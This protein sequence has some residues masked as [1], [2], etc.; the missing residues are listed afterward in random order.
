MCIAIIKPAGIAMPSDEILT[1]CWE[2]NDDGAGMAYPCESGIQIIKGF[3]SLEEFL[4]FTKSQDFSIC[5]VLLHFRIGTHGDK[6]GA[7]HTHPFPIGKSVEEM[8]ST[9]IVVDRALIHNGI[10]REFGYDKAISDTMAFCRDAAEQVLALGKLT[11]G[12]DM[13][14]S[15]LGYNKIAVMEKDGNVIHYGDWI[16]DQGIFWSNSS[17]EEIRWGRASCDPRT[18]GTAN[19]VSGKKLGTI[20]DYE[21]DLTDAEEAYEMAE[22]EDP[23]IYKPCEG[24]YFWSDYVVEILE[25]LRE[26]PVEDEL[27][28]IQQATD[29]GFS[30]DTKVR[31]AG[32]TIW[33]FDCWVTAKFINKEITINQ[34]AS[35]MENLSIPEAEVAA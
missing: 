22:V 20:Y 17:Y 32:V 26:L 21:D 7:K 5:N 30:P 11:A 34:F 19:P 3:K 14:E 1:R 12:R 8:E 10:M 9:N 13:I 24:G 16:Y 33:E 28:L 27:R 18:W 2:R 35:F 4:V 6:Q 25:E 29:L 15:I 23:R 31:P